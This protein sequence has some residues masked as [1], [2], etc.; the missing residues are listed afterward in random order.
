M[1]LRSRVLFSEQKL[2]VGKARLDVVV[3]G[4]TSNWRGTVG[5]ELT[6]PCEAHYAIDLSD[7]QLSNLSWNPAR[8]VL[9][10]RLPPV[11]VHALNPVLEDKEVKP[12]FGG[13]RFKAGR[14]R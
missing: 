2:V 14:F 11:Q 9:R 4:S 10:L 8:K 5:A 12:S 6:M 7:I 1:V 13:G 3:E